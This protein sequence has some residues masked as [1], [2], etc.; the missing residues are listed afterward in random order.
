MEY[1]ISFCRFIATCTILAVS[2]NLLVFKY[3]KKHNIRKKIAL[4]FIIYAATEPIILT[5]GVLPVL[6]DPTFSRNEFSE[7]D[8]SNKDIEKQKLL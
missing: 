1:Q 2:A 8:G 4:S 5:A 6:F 7:N 3:Y